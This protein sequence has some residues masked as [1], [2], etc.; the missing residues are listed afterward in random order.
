M[1]YSSTVIHLQIHSNLLQLPKYAH[2]RLDVSQRSSDLLYI[3]TPFHNLASLPTNPSRLSIISG[4]N[5]ALE[6]LTRNEV[7]S[8]YHSSSSA[9]SSRPLLANSKGCRIKGKLTTRTNFLFTFLQSKSQGI[10]QTSSTSLTRSGWKSTT[11]W[12]GICSWNCSCTSIPHLTSVY[13][14]QGTNTTSL[15]NSSQKICTIA[16]RGR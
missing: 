15:L 6:C 16:R 12:S 7:S 2:Q 5:A 14:L 10:S 13:L 1:F 9:S 11:S 8:H 4:R 3:S